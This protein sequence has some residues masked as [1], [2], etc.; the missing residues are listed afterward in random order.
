MCRMTGPEHAPFQPSH[1]LPF[2]GPLQSRR[3]PWVEGTGTADRCC[4]ASTRA[5]QT[6]QWNTWTHGGSP[7][8]SFAGRWDRVR[9]PEDGRASRR[10]TPN[11]AAT[12]AIHRSRTGARNLQAKRNR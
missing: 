10:R 11:P 2:S 8:P 9:P 4:Y 3:L 12:N 5:C 6:M 1:I 7:T